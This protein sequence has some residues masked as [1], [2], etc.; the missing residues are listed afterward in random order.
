MDRDSE[1]MN[2]KE[3]KLIHSQNS[4]E[5]LQLDHIQ[6]LPLSPRSKEL[7]Y[8]IG[9]DFQEFL[10][11]NQLS[12]DWNSILTY[13]NETDPKDV[14]NR[15]FSQPRSKSSD[16]NP[17]TFNSKKYALKKIL[18]EQASVQKDPLMRLAIQE[19]FKSL[20][21]AKV[22]LKI[23]EQEYLSLNELEQITHYCFQG[24]D[25]LVR[26]GLM[27][28]ALFETGCRVSELIHIEHKHVTPIQNDEEHEHLQ[29][30][31]VGKGLKER[32][33]YMKKATYQKI[34]TF[35]KGSRYLFASEKDTPLFRNNVFRSI[36]RVAAR[37]GITKTVHPHTFRHSCAMH[38]LKN[39]K[40][41][42]KAVSEY[43]GHS[44]VAITLK[45]YVHDMPSASEVL[46]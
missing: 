29:I 15:P 3:D 34:L 45:S 25:R 37:A 6:W 46:S 31:V 16:F 27:V 18:L 22:D 2:L 36:Q 44:D 33:V 9:K 20:K 40:L 1:V 23:H 38:L 41:N 11:Q 42:A 28:H 14:D 43:L 32:Q 39:K 5:K 17:N 10:E 4:W 12:V 30:T 21:S 24:K 19:H 26:I 13:L 8:Q 35:F 7:I